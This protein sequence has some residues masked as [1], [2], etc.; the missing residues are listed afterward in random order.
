MSY[1]NHLFKQT[2]GQ[3]TYF[4]IYAISHIL[5]VYIFMMPIFNHDYCC[6]C[7]WC[8][9]CFI[10]SV[11]VHVS[12]CFH[13]SH[14]LPLES[15]KQFCKVFFFFLLSQWSLGLHNN[16]FYLLSYLSSS[17]CSFSEIC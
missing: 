1:D 2:I 5:F 13:V 16:I 11:P 8:C 4:I 9:C 15:R 10:G 12:V 17:V 7:W 14:S 6:C 3:E